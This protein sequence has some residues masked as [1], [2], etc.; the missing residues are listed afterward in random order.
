MPATTTT[1]EPGYSA[2]YDSSSGGSVA[3]SNGTAVGDYHSHEEFQANTPTQHVEQGSNTNVSG[4][5]TNWHDYDIH[6]NSNS[7]FNYEHIDQHQPAEQNHHPGLE[8]HQETHHTSPFEHS[9]SH[10]TGNHSGGHESGNHGS[11]HH[12][13]S[14]ADSGSVSH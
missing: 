9:G 10:E 13:G 4:H 8:P 11:S 5:F 14:H 3:V 7:H 12:D 1:T 6:E 2:E